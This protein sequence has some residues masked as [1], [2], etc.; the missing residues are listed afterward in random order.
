M[1]DSLQPQIF[2]PHVSQFQILS[3][4]WSQMRKALSATMH[5]SNSNKM[6]FTWVNQGSQTFQ[7]KQIFFILINTSTNAVNSYERFKWR[8]VKPNCFESNGI[9]Q[10]PEDSNGPSSRNISSIGAK[11]SSEHAPTAFS[12]TPA[13]ITTK[14]ISSRWMSPDTKASSCHA[15]ASQVE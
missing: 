8:E 4:C 13:C 9:M 14:I 3:Y 12:S 5:I 1:Q 15:N 6:N 2:Y 11:T 10:K 7:L